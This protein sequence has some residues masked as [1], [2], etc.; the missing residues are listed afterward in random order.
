MLCLT[1]RGRADLGA[2][3]HDLAVSLNAFCYGGCA[4]RL[5]PAPAGGQARRAQHGPTY[6]SWLVHH[7]VLGR[8]SPP[9]E[10][11]ARYAD[12][13]R[14]LHPGAWPALPGLPGSR[15]VAWFA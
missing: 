12:V 2:P 15:R 1:G 11:D 7:P 3:C 10:V 4:L 5:V 8:E 13:W 6:Y 14:T 9:L